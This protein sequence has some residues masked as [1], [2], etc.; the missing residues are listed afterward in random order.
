MLSRAR[1][2]KSLKE[3][4]EQAEVDANAIDTLR[5]RI[6]SLKKLQIILKKKSTFAENKKMLIKISEL[7][8]LEPSPVIEEL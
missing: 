6:N 1:K 7:C 2:I 8:Q 4:E 5:K 3:L